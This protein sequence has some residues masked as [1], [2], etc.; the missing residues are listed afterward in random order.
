MRRLLLLT[1]AMAAGCIADDGVEPPTSSPP[2]SLSV[3]LSLKNIGSTDLD[4]WF[5]YTLGA[6][7][8]KSHWIVPARASRSW[9]AELPTGSNLS[10]TV[11]WWT[12]SENLGPFSGMSYRASGGIEDRSTT[13]CFPRLAYINSTAEYQNSGF[14][15]GL[16]AGTEF[17]LC[18]DRGRF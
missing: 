8:N 3:H 10:F 7:T 5:N 16:A 2:P 13:A 9:F 15:R 18:G 12:H 6:E 14:N 11:D 1:L 17:Y 4:S